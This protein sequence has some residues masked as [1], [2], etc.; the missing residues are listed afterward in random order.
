M[1]EFLPIAK[2]ANLDIMIWLMREVEERDF[3]LLAEID[4][5][6]KELAER[7]FYIE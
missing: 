6:R 5:R 7:H 1:E 2:K 3:L 4:K